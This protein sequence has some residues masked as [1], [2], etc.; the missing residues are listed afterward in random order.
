[1]WLLGHARDQSGWREDDVELGAE[2]GLVA[3]MATMFVSRCRRAL[4]A[5]VLRGYEEREETL[6]GLRGRLREA[7][8]MRARPGIPLPLEVRFD[9]YTINIPENRILRTAAIRM[10]ALGD[11]PPPV[12]MSLA[13]L[14]RE[15]TEAEPL[16]PGTRPPEMTF[17]RLNR[18]YAP[19]LHIAQLILERTSIEHKLG[20]HGAT[21]FLFDM[22]HV[23]EDWL[24]TALTDALEARTGKVRRQRPLALDELDDV[25]MQTDMT[26]W[27]GARCLAVIDAKYKKLQPG[28][29]RPEDLYQVLAYCTALGIRSG[30]LVYAAGGPART[31]VVR[32]A[33]VRI[34]AHVVPLSAP[35]DEVSA[36][37]GALGDRITDNVDE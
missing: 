10:Q 7:D 30:H 33:G 24:T 22:N 25:M 28:G 11:V 34:H 35:R 4:A 27:S 31:L 32:N 1:M 21:G 13:R 20:A 2:T 9:D 19:A 14:D 8:Q 3:A 16:T 26:W 37:V 18:R 23:F 6:P 15:L 12:R 5:G 17:T 36:S 29:P